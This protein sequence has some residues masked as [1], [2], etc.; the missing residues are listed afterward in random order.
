MKQRVYIEGTGCNRRQLD[1]ERVRAYLELND[2]T[3]VIRPED[4]DRIIVSTCAF[5][6]KE[7][8]DSVARLEAMRKYAGKTVVFGCL[9]DIAPKRFAQFDGIPKV[10][11]RELERIESYFTPTHRPF[12]EV[13]DAH[14]L[15]RGAILPGWQVLRR[16]LASAVHGNG[17]P[18]R[19]FLHQAFLAGRQRIRSLA[20]SVPRYYYLLV[21]RGCLGKCSYCAIRRSIGPVISKPA[22]QICDEMNAGYIQGFRNFVVLG[23]DPGCYGVDI[24]SSF[25]ELLETL[26]RHGDSL[27]QQEMPSSGQNVDINFHLKEIHPKFLIANTGRLLQGRAMSRVQELLSPIQSGSDRILQ[28]MQREHTIAD[29]QQSLAALCKRNPAITLSTQLIVGFPGETDAD[30]A[31]SLDVVSNGMY[32]SVVVFPYDDKGGTSAADLPEKVPHKVITARI[33]AAFRH[34]R[35]HG[36]QAYY[37]CPP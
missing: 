22:E 3:V 19:Q 17:L 34:F 27:R 23:D 35:K 33:R 20:G 28:L 7:E 21:C 18:A 36:V 16:N 37:S 26:E 6:K 24:G 14:I 10:A 12:A 32:R 30:F 9:P 15:P 5:K 29:L 31:R 8:D 25:A 4:A 1:L 2:F 13:A 11:P